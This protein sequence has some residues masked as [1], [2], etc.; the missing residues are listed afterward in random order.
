MK[1]I[2]KQRLLEMSEEKI[3][4]SKIKIRK[5]MVNNLLVY[6]PF[7]NG[8]RMGAFRLTPIDGG[9]KVFGT[10]LYDDYK[11]KGFGKGMYRYIIK[12]LAKDG[13]TLYSDDKQSEDATR[14]WDSLVSIGIA[15][16]TGST[17]KSK[18]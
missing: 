13:N 10:V 9:Y 1:E 14:V 17:Y 12:D 11:G 6:T 3:D 7:Y 8:N 15:E 4:T 2:I 5:V 16:K 18:I